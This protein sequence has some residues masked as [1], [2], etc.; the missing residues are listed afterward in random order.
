MLN[1]SNSTQKKM[2]K[3]QLNPQFYAIW[4]VLPFLSNQIDLAR[5]KQKQPPE[6]FL[7]KDVLKNYTNF[8]RKHLCWSLFLIKVYNFIK[9]PQRRCLCVKFAK[10]LRTSIL[11]NISERLLLETSCVKYCSCMFCHHCWCSS[12]LD[13]HFN[14][15]GKNV[16]LLLLTMIIEWPQNDPTILRNFDNFIGPHPPPPAPL[17]SH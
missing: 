10:F 11:K 3:H 6:V 17:L 16:P 1:D 13:C 14:I 4:K 15:L 7:F 8:T 2:T 5:C 9:R 12:V